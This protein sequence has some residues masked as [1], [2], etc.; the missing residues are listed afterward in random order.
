MDWVEGVCFQAVQ[1]VR[2]CPFFLHSCVCSDCDV[3]RGGQPVASSAVVRVPGPEERE[4][5]AEVRTAQLARLSAVQM[6]RSLRSCSNKHHWKVRQSTVVHC[7]VFV[8]R[9]GGPKREERA[10]SG[11]KLAPKR[12]GKGRRKGKPRKASLRKQEL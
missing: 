1:D 7:T 8:Q 10:P 6:H 11:E 9:A 12:K 3:S 4:A 5:M 2:S